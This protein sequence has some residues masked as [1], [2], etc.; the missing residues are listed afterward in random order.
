MNLPN[1]Y[2]HTINDRR[3]GFAL[4][5]FMLGVNMLGRVLVRLPDINGFA[6]GMANNF[7][8]T[9]LPAPFV[10]V[11][12]YIILLVEAVV[13]VLL[14]LGFKTRWALVAL[15]LLLT[16]LAFGMILQQNYG[17]VANILVYGF[18]TTFLLF[19]TRYDYFGAD[20]GFSLDK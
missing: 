18:A 6:E 9:I 4:L 12:A 3:M 1:N 11:Y 19:Y 17:T 2:P 16:T 5:R 15:G 14:I 13:G 20:T 8:D 7:S 10:L